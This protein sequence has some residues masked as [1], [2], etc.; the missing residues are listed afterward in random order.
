MRFRDAAWI[1]KDVALIG[2]AAAVDFDLL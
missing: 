1:V 2:T